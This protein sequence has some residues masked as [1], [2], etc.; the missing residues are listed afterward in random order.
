MVD[1]NLLP[2]YVDDLNYLEFYAEPDLHNS[3]GIYKI[4]FNSVTVR[5]KTLYVDFINND[6]WGAGF[7]VYVRAKNNKDACY[8]LGHVFIVCDDDHLV[9]GAFTRNP[10]GVI[11]TTAEP[12]TPEP[13]TPTPTP[14]PTPSPFPYPVATKYPT[15]DEKVDVYPQPEQSSGYRGGSFT[16]APFQDY[17]GEKICYVKDVVVDKVTSC[18]TPDKNERYNCEF[19]GFITVVLEDDHTERTIRLSD[20]NLTFD[21]YDLNGNKYYRHPS[22]N[23][24]IINLNQSY[25]NYIKLQTNNLTAGSYDGSVLIIG[26]KIKGFDYGSYAETEFIPVHYIYNVQ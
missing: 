14:S 12:T 9:A 26:A 23:Y 25:P 22:W 11:Q 5:N 16:G 21:L 6:D 13:T 10:D 4:T 20:E 18:Y 7:N 24:I 3:G 15:H 2:K 17:N 1:D 8:T 19:G